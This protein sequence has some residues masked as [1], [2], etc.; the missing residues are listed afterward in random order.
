MNVIIQSFSILYNV[1]HARV[2]I[3]GYDGYSFTRP[4][5]TFSLTTH[6]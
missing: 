6:P 5:E 2:N 1:L 4:R 3:I